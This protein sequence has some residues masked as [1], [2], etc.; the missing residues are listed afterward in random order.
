MLSKR[1]LAQ[2]VGSAKIRGEFD[3]DALTDVGPKTNDAV[4]FPAL[5]VRSR[6]QNGRVVPCRKGFGKAL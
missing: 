3:T 2:P 6:R 5:T 4:L 1:E